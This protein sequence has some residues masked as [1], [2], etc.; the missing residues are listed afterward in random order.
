MG[1]LRDGVGPAIWLYVEGRTGGRFYHF[2]P[3]Q[4]DAL[5]RAMNRWLECYAACYGVS[6]E[7]DFTVRTAAELLLETHNVAD[8]AELLTGV[9]DG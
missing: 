7:A 8:V 6:I 4:Y 1:Y 2:T 5:E 9:P 3:D